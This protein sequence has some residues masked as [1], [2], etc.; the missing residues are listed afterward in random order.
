[1]RSEVLRGYA[2]LLR[3][4]RKLFRGDEQAL[5]SSLVAIR[6]E[7][8]ANRGLEDA[9]VISAMIKDVEEAVDMLE[10]Q[11]VQARLNERGNFEVENVRVPEAAKPGS[12]IPTFEPKPID[13][14]R[15]NQEED[16]KP[17][18]QG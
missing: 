8:D 12:A 18:S 11:L 7:F 4:R 15:L 14:E 6:K 2:R 13:V 5:R 10:N 3:A 9:E 16:K 17:E 1:M